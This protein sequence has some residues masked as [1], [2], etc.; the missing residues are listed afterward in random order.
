MPARG[1]P[2]RSRVDRPRSDS[3][4]AGQ[5]GVGIVGL[6]DF[7]VDVLVVSDSLAGI[8][9]SLRITVSVDHPAIDSISLQ[10]YRLDY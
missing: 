6:E 8:T 2:R 7:D 1:G 3:G 4:A 10:S 5:D 9:D